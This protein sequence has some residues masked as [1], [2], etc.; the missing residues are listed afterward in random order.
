LPKMQDGLAIRP[1]KSFLQRWEY[2]SR[3]MQPG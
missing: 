2:P 3:P 1:T